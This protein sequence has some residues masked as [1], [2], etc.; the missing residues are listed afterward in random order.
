MIM[1]L[2]EEA[3]RI[4]PIGWNSLW[5]GGAGVVM[6]L[7]LGGGS[8]LAVGLSVVLLGLGAVTVQWAKRAHLQALHEAL[9][10]GKRHQQAAPPLQ[11]EEKWH[12]LEAT[13]TRLLSSV[14]QQVDAARQQL[15]AGITR[16]EAQ[17]ADAQKRW[18]EV[19]VRLDPTPAESEE[20]PNPAALEG[21]NTICGQALPIWMRQIETAREQTET[22]I[23]QL[24]TQFSGLVKKL[25]GAVS[26]SGQGA[27]TGQDNG[28]LAALNRS[29][30]ELGSVIE[31]LKVAQDGRNA[32]LSEVR[33]LTGYTDELKKMAEEVAKIA[34]QTKLLALNATIEA[35]RAGQAG[36]GFAVVA[37]EVRKLSSLSSE[38]GKQMAEKVAVINTAI[39]GAF[40]VSQSSA[41]RDQQAVQD[42]EMAI[43]NVLERFQSV[44][45]G[46]SQST[47]ILQE[48]S[49]GIRDEIAEVLVSLQ[50]Q[51]RTSQILVQVQ[52]DISRLHTLVTENDDGQPIDAQDWLSEMERSY[53]TREQHHNHHGAT[54]SAVVPSEITFF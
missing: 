53:T 48:A 50:F 35:T 19:E 8:M 24:A 21:L 47:A 46:F 28:L 16:L 15:Q 34:A 29:E 2:M 4:S 38:T 33:D 49:T 45:S 42:A 37:D 51:D 20:T 13:A 52:N 43:S 27:G 18:T 22:A 3:R 7:T 31:A 32:V 5:V 44:A 36:K 17:L 10:Q 40:Q 30:D 26:A 54:A 6:L 9:E 41:E 14:E 23:T 39:T 25:E 11:T 1:R 12:D